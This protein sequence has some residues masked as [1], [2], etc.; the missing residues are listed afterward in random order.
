MKR[1]HAIT[2][3]TLL[4]HLVCRL[5]DTTPSPRHTDRRMMIYFCLSIHTRTHIHV[6]TRTH[7]L[8]GGKCERNRR[9]N[10]LHFSHTFSFSFFFDGPHEHRA[11]TVIHHLN[12]YNVSKMGGF[13]F[14]FSFFS[15][16]FDLNFVLFL[17]FFFMRRTH[18]L[19]K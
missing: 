4:C 13:R 15:V 17:F 18:H 1:K 8:P 16:F 9:P 12:K 14:G 2:I 6:N 11:Q 3:C 10:A 19:I 5:C 7:A